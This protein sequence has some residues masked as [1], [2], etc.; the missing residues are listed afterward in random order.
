MLGYAV[1]VVGITP[2]DF[3][4]MTPPEFKAVAD[5][6]HQRDESAERG[7]WERMRTLAALTVQPHVSKKITPRTLVPLPWDKNK[8]DSNDT[9]T[10]PRHSGPVEKSTPDKFRNL[11]KRINNG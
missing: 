7:A 9:P 4:T 3:R 10:A 2:H 8:C 1:G 5:A 11:L 6:R